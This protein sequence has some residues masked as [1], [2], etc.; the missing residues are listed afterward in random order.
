MVQTGCH[1]RQKAHHYRYSHLLREA[2]I[3]DYH[4]QGFLQLHRRSGK[5]EEDSS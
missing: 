1:L 3:E 5:P 2:Q 4:V